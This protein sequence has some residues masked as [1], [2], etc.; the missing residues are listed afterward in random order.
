MVF[1]RLLKRG[2]KMKTLIIRLAGPLQSYGN[3]A[4]FN[5]RTSFHYPSKSAIIGMIA[6][7][8]GYHRDDNRISALNQLQI[9]VRLDQP[10]HLL[11]DFQ[12]IEYD[13]IHQKRSLSYRDYLQD[14]V[15]VAAIGGVDDQIDKI[16]WALHHP[17]FQLY[18]GRRANVPAGP[19]ITKE[20]NNQSPVHVLRNLRWQAAVWYQRQY[21]KSQYSAEIVADSN[22]VASNFN[23]FVKDNVGGFSQDHR[24]HSYRSIAVTRTALDN[25]YYRGTDHD[26]MAN[27]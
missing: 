19:L 1:R 10:G 18:L 6:A 16:K 23:T 4:T 13:R 25:P 27:I 14:A 5:R 17:R 3:E 22:L 7:A 24:W 21:K 26:I 15:F 2:L 11:T 8:L 9:A 20:F 12:I